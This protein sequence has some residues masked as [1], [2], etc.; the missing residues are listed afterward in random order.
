MNLVAI[1]AYDHSPEGTLQQK[2][3]LVAQAERHG[4]LLVF[5][6]GYVTKAG[7]LERRAGRTALRAVDLS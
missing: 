2:R 6:H 1:S 4:W 7:Y 5:S 3:E